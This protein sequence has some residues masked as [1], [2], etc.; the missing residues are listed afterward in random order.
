MNKLNEANPQTVPT[1]QPSDLGKQLRRAREAN[2]LTVQSV[3]ASLRL[4]PRIVIALEEGDFAQFQPVYVKGY[5]RNY[6]RLLNLSV[7]PLIKSYDR[8]LQPAQIP[9]K[10]PKQNPKKSKSSLVLV[11]P[12]AVIVLATLGWIA[13]TVIFPIAEIPAPTGV[14]A[15]HS[16]MQS[17]DA[18]TI[19]NSPK[20][21]EKL[22]DT[23]GTIEQIGGAGEQ[24]G[25][26]ILVD[27]PMPSVTTLTYQFVGPPKPG[28]G[29]TLD[30][31]PGSASQPAVLANPAEAG[32]PGEQ[33][34]DTIAVHLSAKA[35]V[36]IR[37]HTGRR[38]G[39]KRLPAGTDIGFS[40]QAPFLVVLGNSSATKIQFNGKPYQLP[41]SKAGGITR[42]TIGQNE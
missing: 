42:L 1:G 39:Y 2:G 6:G 8:I 25:A 10:M 40:G 9:L 33:G 38:L 24:P 26:D 29:D 22:S 7:E 13:R 41:T 3:S 32:Q 12:L 19:E 23:D 27:K 36:G 11:L 15:S 16:S 35:W 21:L 31:K 4:T 18:N 34:A 30:G 14:D 20:P 28:S 37:D 5:L 17:G